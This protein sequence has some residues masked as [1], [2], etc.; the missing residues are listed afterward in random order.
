[1]FIC[2]NILKIENY[3]V[4]NFRYPLDIPIC[5]IKQIF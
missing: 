3:L 4:V 2:S 5:P 1:M